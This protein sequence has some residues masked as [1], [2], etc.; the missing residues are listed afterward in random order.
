MKAEKMSSVFVL[1]F[2]NKILFLETKR[3]CEKIPILNA[4]NKSLYSKSRSTMSG[5]LGAIG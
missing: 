3:I 2:F 1:Y 4:I 5:F